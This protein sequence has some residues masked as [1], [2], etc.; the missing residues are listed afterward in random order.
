MTIATLALF[1]LP[2]F[3]DSIKDDFGVSS[4][5]VGLLTG[6]FAAFYALVQVPAGVIGDVVGH[7]VALSCALVLLAASL[8]ASTQASS[9][10][11]LVALRALTG[12][13]AGVLL[14][15]TS[16]LI[17]AAA[18]RHNTRAQAMLGAGWGLGYLLSLLVLP[19]LF[20]SWQ[21]ALVALA[22]IAVFAALVAAL[23]PRNRH[24][25]AA[26]V[27]RRAGR[28]AQR[29]HLA[30]R[31]SH[32]WAHVC[33]RWCRCL[34]DLLLHRRPGTVDE[35]GRT[36]DGAD[37]RRRVSCSDRRC[38]S[39][40]AAKRH[41]SDG[42]ECPGDGSW[43]DHAC[44]LP[45]ARPGG[46]RLLRARVVRSVPV[47]SHAGTHRDAGR[48]SRWSGP[49]SD[50]RS[51]NGIAFLAGMISPPIVG[52][53]LDASGSYPIAFAPLVLGPALALAIALAISARL[54]GRPA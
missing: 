17:R 33:Q 25:H 42:V 10:A 35:W 45:A 36:D 52:L 26:N 30:P 54:H 50:S 1:S 15:V 51:S 5:E 32:V 47:R 37:R 38:R 40:T 22:A 2:A 18:P 53:I 27:R 3:T 19:V 48:R 39:C 11:L 29:R 49:R 14:P 43:S 16:S 13:A 23:L 21:Q 7:N 4:A 12:L 41:A 28:S 31:R 44:A 34:G 46:R 8:L 9:F 20:S 24:P 6:V